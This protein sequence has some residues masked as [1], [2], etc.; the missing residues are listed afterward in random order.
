MGM[1]H[2]CAMCLRKLRFSVG[3]DVVKR[4]Q[5][6]ARFGEQAGFENEAG[7]WSKLV[8]KLRGDSR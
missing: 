2:L 6:L 4:Y 5:D 1:L 7:W 8:E 3:S